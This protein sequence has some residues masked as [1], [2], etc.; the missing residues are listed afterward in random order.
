MYLISGVG[1]EGEGPE[2]VIVGAMRMVE[3]C[4]PDLIIIRPSVVKVDLTSLI[5]Q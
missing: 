2:P 3:N 5:S 4:F 1:C